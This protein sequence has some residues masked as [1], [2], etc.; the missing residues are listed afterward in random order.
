[1]TA[2]SEALRIV[3]YQTNQSDRAPERDGQFF[4]YF[5]RDANSRANSQEET[6]SFIEQ[7]KAQ[8]A[9]DKEKGV[10]EKGGR[11]P[12]SFPEEFVFLERVIGLL[13]GL[14][15]ELDSHCPILHILA[16]HARHGALK[17]H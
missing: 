4:E 14:T 15:A 16:L 17:A 2:V 1:M 13:R 10:R 5:F 12:T 3:G 7:R 9:D 6:K 11:S 8:R